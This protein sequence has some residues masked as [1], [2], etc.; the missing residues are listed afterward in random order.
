MK[1]GEQRYAFECIVR[2]PDCSHDCT[3]SIV[4]RTVDDAWTKA[5]AHA[6]EFA[7]I[8]GAVLVGMALTDIETFYQEQPFEPPYF[9]ESP[10]YDMLF[11]RR[12]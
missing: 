8:L 11:D 2:S 12:N 4:A 5:S 6:V 1:D 7:K 10:L 9:I 3:I